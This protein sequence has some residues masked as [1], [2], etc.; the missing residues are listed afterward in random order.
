[1]VNRLSDQ[2]SNDGFPDHATLKERGEN[3][4][5]AVKLDL[6]C[7][8]DPMYLSRSHLNMSSMIFGQNKS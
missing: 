8:L 2:Q 3:K 6:F 7:L 1:M 4:E 5:K